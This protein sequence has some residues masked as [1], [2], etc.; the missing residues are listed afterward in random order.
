MRSPFINNTSLEL[1]LDKNATIEL[2][3]PFN[4]GG[5]LISLK[6]ESYKPV[7]VTS[8]LLRISDTQE[9]LNRKVITNVDF[10]INNSIIPNYS[11]TD[12]KRSLRETYI[13][14]ET[15]F[16][17]FS[18]KNSVKDY[19]DEINLI[20]RPVFIPIFRKNFRISHIFFYLKKHQS[21]NL[22]L[23]IDDLKIDIDKK[24]R[25]IES[26]FQLS[27]K[28]IL[29]IN[30]KL[31]I[32]RYNNEATKLFPEINKSKKKL[33]LDLWNSKNQE[34]I[35]WAMERSKNLSEQELELYVEINKTFKKIKIK[36]INVSIR[37]SLEMNFL[38]LIENLDEEREFN[39]ELIRKGILTHTINNLSNEIEINNDDFIDRYIKNLLLLF[40]FKD[41]F[42]FFFNNKGDDSI[43]EILS[44]KKRIGVNIQEYEAFR[45]TFQ[46]IAKRFIKKISIN[47]LKKKHCIE[48]KL[49]SN[50]KNLFGIPIYNGN[51]QIGTMV[52]SSQRDKLEIDENYLLYSLTTI[53][54]KYYSNY[55]TISKYKSQLT[56]L[57]TIEK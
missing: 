36:I 54:F 31:Q 21:K 40:D 32:D 42:L 33:F 56:T 48:T 7:W 57:N 14:A 20:Y 44:Q 16:G 19:K 55:Q 28:A 4:T 22:P 1:Y 18:E 39:K 43:I 35:V 46:T 17:N 29:E 10:L 53:I 13:N 27:N 8:E 23:Q 52:Y 50:S 37:L 9:F 5:V 41:M 24:E 12:F 47:E 34:K 15:I 25:K 49:F 2:Q 45:L 30:N 51:I 26:L 3:I 38:I 11:L 6:N